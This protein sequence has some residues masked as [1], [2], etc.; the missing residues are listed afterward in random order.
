M[1]MKNITAALALAALATAPGAMAFNTR[2][3]NRP[4]TSN[5]TVDDQFSRLD[6]D[7]NGVITR[8]EFPGNASQFDRLDLNRDG[9]IDRTEIQQV[10]GQ[11]GG[12]ESRFRGMDRD[13]NGVITRDEWRGND[14]SFEKLDRNRDGVLSNADRGGKANGKG[15]GNGKAKNHGHDRDRDHDRDDD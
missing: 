5:S 2:G 15:H 9:A 7:G 10:R 3:T 6:R 8:N 1:N 13:G 11:R 4:V 12:D 14:K